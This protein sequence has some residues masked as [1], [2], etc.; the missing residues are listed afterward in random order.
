MKKVDLKIEMVR[1]SEIKPDENNVKIH[2]AEQ[3]EQIKRSI[4]TYGFNDPVGLWK[5]NILIEG[6]GRWIAS[7]EMGLEEIPAIR[8]DHLTDEQRKEYVLVHN[9]LTMN[10]GFDIERLNAELSRME[11]FDFGFYG[12]DVDKTPFA[13]E[14]KQQ[15]TVEKMELRA[16][17]HYDYLVFVFREEHDWLKAV[18][19]FDLRRVDGG[20]GKNKKVGVGRVLDGKRLLEKI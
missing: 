7:Q 13:E 18:T 15:R 12:F 6:E 8:L 17:E 3:I 16:F 5:D 10:T 14:L 4:E 11:G 9:K 20:Y 1:V 2:D 19:A